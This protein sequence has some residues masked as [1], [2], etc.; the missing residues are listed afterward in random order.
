MGVKP[1]LV[2]VDEGHRAAES[3]H[4]HNPIGIPKSPEAG[5]KPPGGGPE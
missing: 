4:P 5:W 2:T 3:Q 1:R